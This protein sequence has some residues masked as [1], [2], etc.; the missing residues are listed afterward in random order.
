MK[1][2]VNRNSQSMTS[3]FSLNKASAQ[4]GKLILI[5]DIA[6]SFTNNKMAHSYVPYDDIEIMFP[7]T[8]D[9]QSPEEFRQEF[10]KDIEG[11]KPIINGFMCK[12]INRCFYLGY[13]SISIFL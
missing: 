7:L 9:V 12:E 6:G 8:M 10:L 5:N 11:D 1:Q 3:I 4:K 13:N 2:S